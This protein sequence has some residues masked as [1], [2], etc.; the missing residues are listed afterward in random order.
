MCDEYEDYFT[1]AEVKFN[2]GKDYFLL[3]KYKLAIPLLFEA[4]KIFKKE[5]FPGIKTRTYLAE[6]FV[7]IGKIYEF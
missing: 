6:S 1:K 7:I 3:K 4:I 2:Y 5:E